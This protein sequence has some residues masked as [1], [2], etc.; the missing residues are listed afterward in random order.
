M[1][2]KGLRIRVNIVKI[3][4]NFIFILIFNF[5]F[6]ILVPIL[7]ETSVGCPCPLSIVHN[8]SLNSVQGVCNLSLQLSTSSIKLLSKFYFRMK[9]LVNKQVDTRFLSNLPHNLRK[10]ISTAQHQL[11]PPLFIPYNVEISFNL[12]I[13]YNNLQKILES[14]LKHPKKTLESSLKQPQNAFVWHFI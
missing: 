1:V 11:F 4:I 10:N 2:L 7:T 13:P 9:I 3:E 14:L 12:I 5:I 6:K 8:L